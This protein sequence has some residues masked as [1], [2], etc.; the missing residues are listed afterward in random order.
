VATWCGRTTPEARRQP[1]LVPGSFVLVQDALPGHAVDHRH[2]G[3][4]CRCR[5]FVIAGLDRGNDFL[6]IGA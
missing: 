1:T 3:L 2:G 5:C 6:D 4:E